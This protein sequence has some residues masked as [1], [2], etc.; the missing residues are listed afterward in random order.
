MKQRFE[1][2]IYPGGPATWPEQWTA[3]QDEFFS[4]EAVELFRQGREGAFSLVTHRD[5]ICY[6]YPLRINL[7]S[8]SRWKL[9]APLTVI[10]LPLSVDREGYRGDLPALVADYRRR[11]GLFLLLNLEAP[12]EIAGTAT[13]ETLANCVLERRFTSF[14]EY[15]SALRSPYRRR[16]RKAMARGESLA[17]RQISGEEFTEEMYGLY[18]QVLERSDFPL[19]TLTPAFFRGAPGTLHCL[20]RGERPLAFVLLRKEEGEIAGE[21]TLSF[22][23]GG[24]EY[25]ERDEYDLYYNM[26]LKIVR[27]GIAAGVPVTEF[28][29]TAEHA[30]MRVGC[31]AKPRYMTVFSRNKMLNW[32][33]KKLI[34]LFCYRPLTEEFRPF[35][36]DHGA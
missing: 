19:E 26:L 21:E 7:L 4:P 18:R 15:L 5:Y 8:F 13:G 35:L 6:E 16:L 23:F 14:E 10:G 36:P 28:G 25:T 27:E 3:I 17:W 12:C 29:Q 24:M 9:E 32:L 31:V 30:K 2:K 11:K 1:G 20:F 34:P 22:V 33:L